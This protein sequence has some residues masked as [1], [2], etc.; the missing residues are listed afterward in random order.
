MLPQLVFMTAVYVFARSID[1]A[2]AAARVVVVGFGGAF[3]VQVMADADDLLLL[4]SLFV[5][6]RTTN[7]ITS[8]IRRSPMLRA[9]RIRRL[10]FSASSMASRRA[11]RFW[12]WR[13]RLVALG[14]AG[15]STDGE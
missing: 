13:S 3:D 7:R 6:C 11:S 1:I 5:N 10:R 12:R 2:G 9:V 4:S 15:E 8:G 14:T